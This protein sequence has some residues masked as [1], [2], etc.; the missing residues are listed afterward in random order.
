MKM[1]WLK[2]KPFAHRGLHGPVSGAVENSPSA[3]EAARQ[4]GYGFEL[5]VL[6]SKDN[7][8]IVFHD[9]K[10]DR[11][12]DQ[13]G[14]L[15]DFTAE[16]LS[17]ITLKNSS[18]RIPTLAKVLANNTSKAPILVE[19]KGNQ[20][21]FN[22]I[23]EAVLKDLSSYDGP[24][25]VMS[26]YDEIV[27]WFQNNVPD[28]TRGLVATAQDSNQTGSPWFDPQEHIFQVK[29]LEPCFLAYDIRSLP[30]AC[31]EYCRENKI[32]VMTWT[33]R[34]DEQRATARRYADNIIFEI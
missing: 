1:D 9:D 16:E 18:D 34:T 6:L 17:R 29:E 4:Q 25:A 13:T 31:T 11:L 33:V 10:L 14:Q 8:A 5:D 19:I 7:K 24:V 27:H 12:T 32:P 22:Q 30:N 2:D 23:A 20:K 15:I 28:I 21:K 3:F 26:F